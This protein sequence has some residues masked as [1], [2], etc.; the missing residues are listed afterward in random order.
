MKRIVQKSLLQYVIRHRNGYLAV[1]CGSLFLN[2]LLSFGV[3]TMAGHEKIIIVPPKISQSFWV[4]ESEV[5]PEYLVEMSHFFASLRFNITPS[6]AENQRE[7]LL[8]YVSPEYYEGLKVELITE[9]ERIAKE[10]ISTVFYPVDTKVDTRH[11]TTLIIGDLLSTVGTNTLPSQRV[12]YKIT[13]KYNEGRLLVKSFE[14]V[15][16]HA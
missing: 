12:T 14:E 3:I 9:S 8:R 13:Y 2:I 7:M 6:N 10:H 16:S 4:T 15:K 5:S 1:A 11:L